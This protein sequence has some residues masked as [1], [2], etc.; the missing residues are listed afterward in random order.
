[1]CVLPDYA[2][3]DLELGHKEFGKFGFGIGLRVCTKDMIVITSRVL[4]SITSFTALLSVDILHVLHS[5][6]H[7]AVCVML[8]IIFSSRASGTPGDKTST[9]FVKSSLQVTT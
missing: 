2:R 8:I 1:M 3:S 5:E 4:T 6:T 7:S 9:T